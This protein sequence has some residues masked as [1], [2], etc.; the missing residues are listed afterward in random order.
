[1][2]PPRGFLTGRYA[3]RFK[4]VFGQNISL[5]TAQSSDRSTPKHRP[6]CFS[7]TNFG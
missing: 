1:M 2:M 3:A 7:Q 5:R 6:A 4:E